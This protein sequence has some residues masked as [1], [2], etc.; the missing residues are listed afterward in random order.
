MVAFIYKWMS[1]FLLAFINVDSAGERTVEKAEVMHPFYISVTE[2]NQNAAD[3]TLEISCKFFADD[4]EQTLEKAYKTQLDITVEKYKPS[5]DK[6]IPDYISKHLVISVDG[7]PMALSYIGFE[8]DKESVYAYFE[9]RNIG[10][11]KAISIT[12][13]LLHD[14]I[15]QQINIMHVTVGGKRQSTKLNYPE[16][17]GA[18]TF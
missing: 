8:K 14:F 17:K 3:K 1:F 13:S 7:K 18:F 10:A 5:F 4:F 6:Y 16:T 9:L 15:T 2:I 11:V 12:N